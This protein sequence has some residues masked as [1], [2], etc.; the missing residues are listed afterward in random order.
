MPRTK[1]NNAKKGP[2]HIQPK[3][4]PISPRISEATARLCC[5]VAGPRIAGGGGGVH[6]AG[7][8]LAQPYGCGGVGKFDAGA[9]VGS[10]ARAVDIN[11]V[12]A[13]SGLRRK[14]GVPS[15]GQKLR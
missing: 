15:L 12:C 7:L 10:V 6:C 8:S 13:S 3:V 1:A 14:S 9:V 4:M 11:T 5:C 2:P